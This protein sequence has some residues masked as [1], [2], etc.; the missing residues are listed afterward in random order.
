MKMNKLSIAIGL[1]LASAGAQAGGPLYIHE[2]TM[3]P[4]KWDTSKGE[5]P[6]YTDGGPMTPT[7]DGGEAPAFTVNYDG[8]VFLSIEQANA[9]TAKAVAE[10]SNVETSTLRMSIQGTIEEQ[11]GI[12]DVNE[13]NV[14]EIYAKENGYGF[15][16]N[17]DTDGQILEQYFGVPKNQVLGIAFPEWADEET[18]EILEATALM[19]GWFVDINDTEGEMVAG[20]FT[21]EFGHA[22]NMSHSQAN[23]HFSYMAAAYRPYYDGVPGCD[24]ANVYK[25]F[26]K[27]AADTIETMFPYI[28]VRGEQGRQQASISVRDDIVNISDLYPT[29]AYKT[30]YGSITGKLYLKDGVSEYSGI[31]MVARNIDNPMYDVITQQSGNQTQGLV[32]PD[33]TFT[34]NGLQPGARYVLYTDTIKAGGY[35]TA[36]TSIV[37]E[38]EYWN[39]GESTN[40]A[41]DR[42]CSFTPITVQAGETKRTDMYFN[43]YE[44]GIQY[45]PLVQAFV[46]DLAKNGK[47]AFG[48]VGNGIPFI[49]DAVQ[50]S[51]SLHPNVD[52]RTN[53]GKMNKNATKAVTTADL[54]GNGIREPVMWD[55]ASNQ[56]KPMQDLNGNSCGGSG[57]LG[58]QAASVWDMDDTGEVMVGL[59]YKD[60]D[61]DG[62]CQR[63]GGGEMVPVK[64]DKHGNIEELPYDIPG[65]VQ[66]VRADRVSGNGE[67]ITGSNTYKQVAWVDGE[68]RDLYSEFGAKNA[69]AMTRDGSMV[70][71]DTDTGVQLW[72]TKTDELESIGGL[73]WCED[74]DYNHFFLGNLCTN[75]RY[76]AEFVQNYFGPI[77][78]MPIDMNEDGSVIVGRA[79]SFFT[80]FIGAVYLE[81]IGWINTRDFFNKQGVVEASQFPVDNPLALSGDGSEMMGNLA[82]ATITFDIDM[83]TAFV[84]KD[85]QDREVSFPKQL[86]AEVQGGAEFGRCA[87]LND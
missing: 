12:A 64:W 72:N 71:L 85:G 23:G 57:S 27:P 52:L 81:G 39:A 41:E 40:P 34:I 35:P 73:T 82:G 49:Y 22:M 8:T 54:D 68:F 42:A 84:C 15:W 1:A 63:N 11:T 16:V 20:V 26:P 31:N 45:T 38:S 3:Q 21:H 67:V 24:T 25:G 79:G 60:V 43:G 66:W 75:P 77:Q 18:G 29:E 50:K 80:G 33:G 9:V 37:S 44:D 76:G 47:K 86:I 83:D 17:Y 32:G 74:M 61:G 55:L 10:W 69:T 65:Y 56:L 14:G 4:Y 58:T 30:Q 19:N 70:A 78:V 36:P 62:N 7:A 2:P 46:T 28:N 53:G 87:H 5:I 13:T 51:Y 6:V 48:T 59:G